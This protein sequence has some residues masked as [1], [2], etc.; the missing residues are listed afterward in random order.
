MKKTLLFLLL[1]LL[2]MGK[3]VNAGEITGTDKAKD[4]A[5]NILPQL[6]VTKT[7]GKII[8]DGNLDDIGWVGAARAINFTQAEP[9]DMVKP[10]VNTTAM[11]TYDDDNLYI[12]VIA[13]DEDPSSI[14]S[15]LRDRDKIFSDDIVGFQLDTYGDASWAYQIFANPNGIQGDLRW[16]RE[17]VDA[18]FDII[19]NSKGIITPTGYQVEFSI[20]FASLRFPDRKIQ[21]WKITFW[22]VRPRENFEEY[23]WAAIS[24]NDPCLACQ[25]GSLSGIKDIVPGRSIEILP[26]YN[27]IQSGFRDVDVA[28][29]KFQNS[30]ATGEASIGLRYGLSSNTSIEGT[31][32]PD[33]SQVESDVAQIDVNN[34]FA[35][36]FP[37]RRP[38][39]QEGSDLFNS[40]YN[41]VHTR[42]I[43]DPSVAAKLTSRTDKLSYAYLA[44]ID[45]RS[46]ILI[47]GEEES[48]IVRNAGKSYSNILR[49]RRSYGD[50]SHI[51][52]FAVDRRF[53][54]NGSGTNI[55][56]DSNMRIR[57]LYNLKLQGVFSHTNEINDTLLTQGLNQQLFDKEGHT[58]GMDGESFIGNALFARF[59]R[60]A[61]NWDYRFS[62]YQI[63]PTYRAD[64]GFESGNNQIIGI[65]LTSYS[66][67]P[68]N[69]LF[70]EIQPILRAARIWNYDGIIKNNGLAPQILF[71]LRGQTTV[72]LRI[73]RGPE[74]FRGIK[75][76][77]Q[78]HIF[79]EVTTQFSDLIQG[80][81][82]I[83]RRRTIARFKD[84]LISADQL[85]WGFTGTIK[86]VNR[87]VIESE[88]ESLDLK[89]LDGN[90]LING[91]VFRTRTEYQ[92]SKEMFFR[93]VVQYNDFSKRMNIEPLLTY[94]INPFSVFF[95]GSTHSS[96]ESV[97]TGDFIQSERQFFMKFQYLFRI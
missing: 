23:S 63:S 1:A 38:F 78:Q 40:W 42:S 18:S 92:I 65:F 44:A 85:R 96:E 60:N 37:E 25:F 12:A 46:P 43:N 17:D 69:S 93:F 49:M 83:E 57:K 14:R 80:G 52:F 79:T 24:K 91:Y 54:G 66:F 10:Q 86:P 7:N 30:D 32:N 74:L 71:K 72:F 62:Y 13:F 77:D 20:P 31:I 59:E 8:I 73:A 6:Q 39:F 67:L 87:L 34:N 15:S 11:I 68:E 97:L 41:I 58:V 29:S 88:L 90:E 50:N 19:Y 89:D 4:F 22:R 82:W 47:P 76:T 27:A 84:P 48:H 21:E 51:G 56:V 61:R 55:S 81:I 95:I 36:F 2:L 33:F 70:V 16:T 3:T 53:E 28:N 45:E 64:N 5:P 26:S 75:F 35:L 94:K 9:V